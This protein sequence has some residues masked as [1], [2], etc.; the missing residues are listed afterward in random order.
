MQVG[1][2]SANKDRK[3]QVLPD[4]HSNLDSDKLFIGI[5]PATEL[6]YR[7]IQAKVLKNV[8]DWTRRARVLQTEPGSEIGTL[9]IGRDVCCRGSGFC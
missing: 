3:S 4:R 9:S 2:V 5:G 1:I 8:K 7:E 6:L